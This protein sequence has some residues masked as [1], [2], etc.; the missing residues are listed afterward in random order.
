MGAI[1][2][3]KEVMCRMEVVE[4]PESVITKLQDA[5]DIM[6]D[7]WVDES[8]VLR[9]FGIKKKSLLNLIYS[10]KITKDMY[11]TAVNGSRK[12]DYKKIIGLTR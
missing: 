1:R 6:D 2:K 11:C 9:E 5:C 7:G 8:V 3:L 12:Y 4:L 10:G